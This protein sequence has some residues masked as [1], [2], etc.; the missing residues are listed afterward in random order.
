MSNTRKSNSV[1]FLFWL[2]SWSVSYS[3]GCFQVVDA[4]VR[5]SILILS[6]C[7]ICASVPFTY[8]LVEMIQRIVWIVNISN[9]IRLKPLGKF[10]NISKIKSLNKDSIG[11][12]NNTN[13]SNKLDVLLG[14]EMKLIQHKKT[15]LPANAIRRWLQLVMEWKENNANK[16]IEDEMNEKT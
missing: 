14:C 3:N 15:S 11:M 13:K 4:V 9:A 7:A 6:D 1:C 5:F 10:N 8:S 16:M 2:F 12:E